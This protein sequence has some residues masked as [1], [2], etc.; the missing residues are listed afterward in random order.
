MSKSYELVVKTNSYAGNFE[1][2]MCAYMTGITGFEDST[3]GEYVDE[4]IKERFE[5]KISNKQ[6][7]NGTWRPVIVGEDAKD[8]IIFLEDKLEGEDLEFLEKRAKEFAIRI[9]IKVLGLEQYCVELIKTR[10]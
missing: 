5:Q 4:E 9:G 7:D 6:D 3:G 1:R 2:E 8:F 10:I